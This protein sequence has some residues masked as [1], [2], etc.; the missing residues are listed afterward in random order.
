MT[1]AV[2]V[3]TWSTLWLAGGWRWLAHFFFP[4]AFL[5]IAIPWPDRFEGPFIQF[6]TQLNATTTVEILSFLGMPSVRLGNLILIEPGLVGVQEACSGLR[7]FQ[8]TLMVSLFLGELFRFDLWRR[9]TFV[10]LG[11]SLSMLFNIAWMK[12]ASSNSACGGRAPLARTRPLSGR[13]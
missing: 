7:F 8:S 2:A 9:L 12:F 6:L 1:A 5:F 4:V 10:V 11:T 13:N 3:L